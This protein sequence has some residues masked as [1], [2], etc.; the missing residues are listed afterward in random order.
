MLG[1]QELPRSAGG[2]HALDVMSDPRENIR[3]LS[4]SPS[5]VKSGGATTC[6]TATTKPV[7]EKSQ[8]RRVANVLASRRS[9]VLLCRPRQLRMLPLPFNPCWT[10]V[11]PLEEGP[12]DEA[13]AVHPGA[14][15]GVLEDPQI[16]R[17]Y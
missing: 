2:S 12:G 11:W 5:A 15:I 17:N 13:Q 6:V 14:G 9:L 4:V 8:F 1:L 10:G 3:R 7:Y 16:F